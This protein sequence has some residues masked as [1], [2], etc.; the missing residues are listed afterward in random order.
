MNRTQDLWR[1]SARDLSSAFRRKDLSPMEA[2]QTCLSRLESVNPLVN[3][4]IS[5]DDEAA[6]EAAAASERRWQ[7]GKPLSALDGVPL[8]VKD[9]I[10]VRGLPATWGSRLYAGF[11]PERDELPVDRLR[12]A[13]AVILGKTN[14]PEFTLQGY[15]DNRVFGPTRNPWNL[16][17]TPGGSSGGAVAAVASG[18]GP[19]AIGTDGGGSIR[20][21]SSHTGL[22]GLKPSVGRVARCDGFPAILLNCEV[23]GP[24][25]RTV[26]DVVMAMEIMAVADPR[27][28]LSARYADRPFAVGPARKCRILYVET[29]GD[30]PVDPEIRASVALAADRLDVLGHRVERAGRFTLVD[31][32]NERVWPVISQAGLAWLLERHPGWQGQIS[33]GLEPLAEAGRNLSASA[34]VGALDTIAET[35]RALSELFQDYD[36][37]LTPSA[38]ALPWGARD[39]FPPTIDGRSVGPRGHAVFTAFANAAGLPA[40]NLPSAPSRA[41]PPIGFQ[42]VGPQGADPLLCAV[43]RGYE[44]AHSWADRWPS[45]PVDRGPD[46]PAI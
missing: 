25:A 28:P 38:A 15:T 39:I 23:I 17:L 37:I 42:L 7:A 18:I 8:T 29:F 19:L 4:V 30:A 44:D 35:S 45:L 43:A 14:V 16:G 32:I 21:P 26:D 5:R 20:R 40:M 36:L 6:R 24:I 11:V 13:G 2:L 1:W 12:A 27:D 10:P 3:A 22:V 9:N 34:F 31:A 41:G 46:Q 33:E